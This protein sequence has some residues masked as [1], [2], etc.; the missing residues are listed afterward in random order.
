MRMPRPALF[1]AV[2]V[3]AAGASRVIHAGP[4]VYPT[5]TTI[6][7]PARAW[8]GY[9]VFVLPQTG[10]VLID[11]NGKAV[12]QWTQFE[13]AS[14]GPTRLLPGGRVIGAIGSRPPHQ[15]SLGVAQFDWDDKLV[16][17]FDH[18]EQVTMRDGQTRWSARQHHDWQREGLPAGYYSPEAETIGNGGRTLILAHRNLAD[19]SIHAQQLEDDVLYEVD[20][21]GEIV[22]EWLASRHVSEMGFDATAREAI[23]APS[24]FNKARESVDWL[25]INGATYVGPNRWFDG[26][27]ERFR[28]NNV[29]ISSRQ[30]NIMMIVDRDGRIVWRLGPDYRDSDGARAIG[31]IIGQH[32]AHI[33]PKGLPG[34]GNLLVFDNGGAAGYGFISPAAPN[35]VNGVGRYS[36]RVLEIDPV[37]LKKVWEYSIGGNESY[38]FFSHYISSAQRLMNGNT[39]ITEGADGRLFEI[40]TTGE[41]VW[42]YVSPYFTDGPTAS[43]RVYRAYRLPYSWVPQLP[44]PSERAVVP[45]NIREFRIA[46]Q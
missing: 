27:D 42:E 17:Q 16:W 30:A 35:G 21:S 45:P 8:S 32:H 13:G 28:P 2:A 34:A 37:T 10:A 6:Y 7:D 19:A 33:I 29:L 14:G 18:A 22:W 46:P 36:S 38:R 11:M 20:G 9:T 43:N 4:T 24:Q 41:I 12:R 1:L 15:E 39:L 26:G 23:R 3:V 31:Q 44:K 40:T 25:H 5:G